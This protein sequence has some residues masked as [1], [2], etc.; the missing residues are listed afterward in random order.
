MLKGRRWK[1]MSLTNFCDEMVIGV[2]IEFSHSSN[3][4]NLS[5]VVNAFLLLDSDF[6][7]INT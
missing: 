3:A 7:L 6:F 2:I 4:V 5:Y 1:N